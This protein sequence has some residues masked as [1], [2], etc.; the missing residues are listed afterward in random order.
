VK[1]PPT[2][3]DWNELGRQF[4]YFQNLFP[5]GVQRREG[6]W[7]LIGSKRAVYEFSRLAETGARWRGFVGTRD[8]AVQ[9]WLNCLEG[10][11]RRGDL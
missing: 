7:E 3:A 5:L 8:Q 1:S 10:H 6:R 2:A 11:L 9:Y 4:S